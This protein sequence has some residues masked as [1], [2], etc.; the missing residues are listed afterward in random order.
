MA[1]VKA[2][3]AAESH[4]AEDHHW[5]FSPECL[6]QLAEQ[7]KGLPVTVNFSGNPIGFVTGAERDDK[8]V[9]LTMDLS[10]EPTGVASPGYRATGQ[11][12][13]DDFTERIITG[14]DLVHVSFTES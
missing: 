10:E 7:A 9:M 5:V 13:N 6:D 12:W 4:P 2:E 14:A 1:T 11:E 8:G 3:L